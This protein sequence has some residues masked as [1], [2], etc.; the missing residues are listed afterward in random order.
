MKFL[1]KEEGNTVFPRVAS[2]LLFAHPGHFAPVVFFLLIVHIS[3]RCR[4]FLLLL[5]LKSR[6][7]RRGLTAIPCCSQRC[8]ISVS[9]RY[10]WF[11]FYFCNF[12]HTTFLLIHNIRLEVVPLEQFM[13]PGVQR[14]EW[15]GIYWRKCTTM[16][17]NSWN[18]L[19]LECPSCVV[20]VIATAARTR[21]NP[22][23]PRFRLTWYLLVG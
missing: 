6:L 17:I 11:D 7:S 23:P 2:V 21:A 18:Y 19:F 8:E 3:L 5:L 22:L 16:M 13:L 14:G 10:W 4:Q 1:L 12:K 15:W 20:C 9:W